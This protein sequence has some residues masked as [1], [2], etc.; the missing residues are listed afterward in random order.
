MEESYKRMVE[1]G[2]GSADASGRLGFADTFGIFQDIAAAHAERIGVGF[3]ALAQKDMFWLT[4]KTQVQFFKRPRIMSEAELST[5]PDAPGRM[6]GCRSYRLTQAGE[7]CAVGKTEWAVINTSTKA[8]VQ[9]KEVYPAELT[10][11]YA[12]VTDEPFARVADDF[13][14]VEPYARYTVRST[15]IDVGGHMNNTA[16]VRA[17]M[18]SL[19]NKEIASLDISR[20][21][22]IF[23]SQCFEGDELTMQKISSDNGLSICVSKG[24]ETV[25]QVRID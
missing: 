6:R 14:G 12:S 4:V 3:A 9:M 20:I 21:D 18:G 16:Y 11:P 17:V 22:V 19:S 1:I 7:T 10:F 24:G 25:L 8:L 5:W 15:D 13:S 23:R 2:P